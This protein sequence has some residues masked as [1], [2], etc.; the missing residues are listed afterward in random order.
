MLFILTQEFADEVLKRMLG[1][2][3]VDFFSLDEIDISALTETGNIM[4]SSYINALA[5]LTNVNVTLSVPRNLSVNMLGGILSIPMATMG[6][7]SDKLMMINAG[8]R[9]EGKELK[10]D[11]ILLPDVESLNMLMKKL[12]VD[13]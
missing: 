2:E 10:S 8:F 9:L 5:S 4:I 1:R 6:Y 11:M 12:G 3:G 7:Y 13:S